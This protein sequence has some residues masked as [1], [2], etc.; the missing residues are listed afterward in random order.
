[1]GLDK[2]L[3]RW[4]EK[5]ATGLRTEDIERRKFV[6]LEYAPGTRPVLQVDDRKLEILTISEKGMKILNTRR[7]EFGE[8]ISGT[9]IFSSGHTLSVTGRIVWQH[10]EE[11]GLFISVI[12]Q[13]IILAEVK[14]LLK[15]MP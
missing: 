11:L 6:R 12:P 9:V 15:I 3:R 7:Q 10:K 14:A 1:M 8:M 4:Q 13:S 5:N 2:L